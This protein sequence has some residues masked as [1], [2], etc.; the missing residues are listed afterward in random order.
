MSNINKAR[1]FCSDVEKLALKYNLPFFVVTDGASMT[2]NKNCQAVSN[3]RQKHIEWEKKHS[4][5]SD[6][7]WLQNKTTNSFDVGI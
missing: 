3:A 2:R 5:D 4:I 7:D 6:E 1:K